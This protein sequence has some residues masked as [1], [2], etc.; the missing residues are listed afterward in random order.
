MANSESEPWELN[1]IVWIKYLYLL[2][3]RVWKK[4]YPIIT[5]KTSNVS[6]DMVQDLLKL[7]K[8]QLVD[9]LLVYKPYSKESFK[10]WKEQ[11]GLKELI[12]DDE[13]CN[14]IHL[15]SKEIVSMIDNWKLLNLVHIILLGFKCRYNMDCGLQFFDV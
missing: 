9:N 3:F 8:G 12:I 15:L 5:G 7:Y 10:K 13:M 6:P 4:I 14:F 11:S 2:L 1:N